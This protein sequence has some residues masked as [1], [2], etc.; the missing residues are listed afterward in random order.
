MNLTPKNFERM[1]NI[2]NA[3]NNGLNLMELEQNFYNAHFDLMVDDLKEIDS[4]STWKDAT[5]FRL[6]K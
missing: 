1:L 5:K 3:K 2:N 6:R 4:P